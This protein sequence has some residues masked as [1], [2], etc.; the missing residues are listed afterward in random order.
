ME[1]VKYPFDVMQNIF[2]IL[3][4]KTL[5]GCTFVCKEWS[6]LLLQ[7]DIL[8]IYAYRNQCMKEGD[9][10]IVNTFTHTKTMQNFTL[11]KRKEAK[12]NYKKKLSNLYFC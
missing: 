2:S 11:K 5:F 6:I 1:L 10:Y 9:E 7:N 3:N 12:Q 4:T 8:W